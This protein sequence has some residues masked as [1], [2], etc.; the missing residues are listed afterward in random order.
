MGG[1]GEERFGESGRDRGYWRRLVETAVKRD[2]WQRREKNRRPVSVSASPWTSGIKRRATTSVKSTADMLRKT[3]EQSVIRLWQFIAL[4]SRWLISHCIIQ[5]DQIMI[6]RNKKHDWRGVAWD[7]WH[8]ARIIVFKLWIN[9]C[10][11]TNKNPIN[12]RNIRDRL[13]YTCMFHLCVDI[14]VTWPK[15]NN[16]AQG[17]ALFISLRA[18]M[19]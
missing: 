10:F 16:H 12:I 2:Q 18:L 14:L 6:G 19:S 4:L 3:T 11:A 7:G 8:S 9:L 13:M 17:S 1:Q 5:F 15:V